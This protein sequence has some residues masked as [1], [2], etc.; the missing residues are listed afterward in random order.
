MLVCK[1]LHV[2]S[3]SICVRRAGVWV[4]CKMTILTQCRALLSS[5]KQCCPSYLNQYHPNALLRVLAEVGISAYTT[6]ILILKIGGCDVCVWIHS[7]LEFFGI[8]CYQQYLG[9]VVHSRWEQRNSFFLYSW[10]NYII[11][12][13]FRRGNQLPALESRR[14]CRLH[15]LTH[16]SVEAA[17]EKSVK[18]EEGYNRIAK[19]YV[20]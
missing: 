12:I 19:F 6:Y 2:W 3:C 14:R 16:S 15:N 5:G 7:S 4:C 17:N 1:G 8:M 11:C 13:E 20:G 9:R 10:F 18:Y